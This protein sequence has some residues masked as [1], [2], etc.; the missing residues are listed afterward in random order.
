MMGRSVEIGKFSLIPLRTRKTRG[1]DWTL[2]VG[3]SCCLFLEALK[4]E[5]KA[6]PSFT[7]SEQLSKGST[8]SQ[9]RRALATKESQTCSESQ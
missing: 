6:T 9:S 3:N 7:P 1:V 5:A 4:I 2:G 8:D